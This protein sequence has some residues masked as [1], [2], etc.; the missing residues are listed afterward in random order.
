MIDVV[1]P[2]HN[3]RAITLNCL[4]LLARQVNAEFRVTVVDDGS[5]DGT[6]EAIR[7]RFPNV[8]VLHGDGSLWWGG[9]TNLG[10]RHTLRRYPPAPYILLLND[11]LEFGPGY[12]ACMER[13]AVHHPGCLIGSLAVYNDDP[14]RVFWC[15]QAV[16]RRQCRY[17][18]A[19]REGFSGS[20]PAEMLPGRGMLVPREVFEHVGLLDEKTFPQHACDLDFSLRARKAGYRLLCCCD[21]EVVVMASQTGPGSVHRSDHLGEFLHAFLD[22]RS[23]NHLP[24]LWRFRVRHYGVL[25]P[26]W[27]AAHVWKVLAGDLLRRTGLR[28]CQLTEEG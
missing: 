9:A 5:S 17:G 14:K 6:S 13:C 2:V 22:I 18:Y 28:R 4:E 23:P 1:I 11:D 7:D 12:L 20:V 16:S 8:N 24:T 27:F 10:I 15:G 21:T 25:G 19:R 3:R 26:L